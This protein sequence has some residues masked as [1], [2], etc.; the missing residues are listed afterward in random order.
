MFTLRRLSVSCFLVLC[1][2]TMVLAQVEQELVCAAIE[3]LRESDEWFCTPI[4]GVGRAP[5]RDVQALLFDY[6]SNSEG[7]Q[8]Q[9]TRD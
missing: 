9:P 2:L 8:Q 4:G 7:H 6:A 1:L 3:L 5:D